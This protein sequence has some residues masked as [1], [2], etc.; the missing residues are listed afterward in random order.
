MWCFRTWRYGT[1]A[2]ALLTCVLLAGGCGFRPVY[3]TGPQGETAS[4]LVSIDVE[5]IADRV[6]QIL[7]NHLLE[8]LNPRGKPDRPRYRLS[9]SL[10][11]SIERIAFRKTEVATRA[12]LWLR[13]S[14][15]LH[16]AED[17]RVLDGLRAVVSSFNILQSDYA[18]L[19]AE[20]DARERAARQLAEE[21]RVLL[22]ARLTVFDSS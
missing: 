3:G 21:L 5:P 1:G 14:F 7:H 12:N 6:G 13:A 20:R 8:L 16:G 19:A 22:A 2:I 11:E 10:K 4:A 17:Q 18:T 9:V 15:V